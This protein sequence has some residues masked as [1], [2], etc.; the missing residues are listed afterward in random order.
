MAWPRWR[1]VVVAT[2]R[3]DLRGRRRIVIM[4]WFAPA[5]IAWMS[6]WPITCCMSA[7]RFSIEVNCSLVPSGLLLVLPSRVRGWA[8]SVARAGAST[9]PAAFEHIASACSGEAGWQWMSMVSC[10]AARWGGPGYPARGCARLQG[11]R[12]QHLRRRPSPGAAA[13]HDFPTVRTSFREHLA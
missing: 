9:R 13:V 3:C 8:K 5:V 12:E 11:G 1:H 4:S 2:R 7:S 10:L 6:I